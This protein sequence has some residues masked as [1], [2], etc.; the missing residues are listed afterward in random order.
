MMLNN[1][2]ELIKKG[3]FEAVKEL[4]YD[5]TSINSADDIILEIPKDKNHGDYA[6]NTAMR[7]SKV[8]KKNPLDIAKQI[9]D[10]LDLKTLHLK[11]A[12]IAGPGFIN[13]T[14]DID[15]LLSVITKIN[16]EKQMYGNTNYGQKQKICLEFVSANPTGYLHLGHGRGAAYGDSLA[17]IMT[18]AGFEV[19]KEHYVNDAGNQITNMAY[20]V[21]E[22]Y[23]ELF[24]QTANMKE[25]YYYGKE[26]IKVASDILDEYQDKFLNNF[27]L[28]FFKAYGTKKLLQNLKDDL[29]KF[30]V[31]FD[32]WFSEKSLYENNEVNK[33][34][35]YLKE[36][37]Y[38]YQ[39]EG[40]LWLK[41]TLYGDEKDRVIIKSDGSYTYLLPDI[42]Y[43]KNKLS[44]GYDHLI[45]VLGADHHGYINRLKA[46]ITMV[47]G[48][49]QLLDVEILQMVRVIE[50]GEEVKM[51]KRSGKAITL[52]D[53][54]DEVGSD[55]LRY[56]YVDKALS[57][58]MD[59]DL[60]LMKQKSNENPVFYAQYAY[61]R[62]CSIF[63]N[64]TNANIKFQK[65][66]QFTK[67]DKNSIKDISLTLLKYPLI[68]EEIANSRLV[69]KLT[70]YISELAYQL[71]SY[72][73]DEKIITDDLE[74]TMEKLNVLEAIR[75]VLKDALTL[76][77][78]STPEK[79]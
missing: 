54:I 42:A 25:D 45:D 30:N 44:R 71:H 70:Q 9:I 74:L 65:I 34:L 37:G 61:A 53:L 19:H 73:N 59:L 31:S 8:A 3:I 51:S 4:H 7:L 62:I 60:T 68:I 23:K 15:Y 32:T 21:Y 2:K 18:K 36:K 1:L 79:M 11:Q 48:N 17:R 50:N 49:A 78:V 52:I 55:A 38:T 64:A 27:D 69:H 16:E 20:S 33:T 63:R 58:H 67:I 41:T 57:T 39:N 28:A 72:Y 12:T 24:G 35:N 47:G 22:R 77:G 76:I 56:F 29:L 6:T 43:H 13:L 10:L 40:A 66:T 26:I 46:A 14:I 5:G 75:I